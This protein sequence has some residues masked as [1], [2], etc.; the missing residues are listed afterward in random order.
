MGA[1]IEIVYCHVYTKSY[2][3]A[4]LVGAWIEIPAHPKKQKTTMVAP[5]VGA[6]IEILLSVST[7]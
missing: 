4:P 7:Y 6:W 1:W 5:L 3:V 2:L